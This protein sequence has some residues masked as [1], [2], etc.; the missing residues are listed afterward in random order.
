MIISKELTHNF[1]SMKEEENKYW[2][3]KFGLFKYSVKYVRS[4]NV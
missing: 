4:K 3:K 1:W 2:A